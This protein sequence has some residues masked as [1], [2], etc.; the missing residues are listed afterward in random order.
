MQNNQFFST[1]LL[2]CLLWTAKLR[3]LPEISTICCLTFL[4]TCY[5]LL[6]LLA[7]VTIN[8]KNS[9]VIKNR[10]YFPRCYAGLPC[11]HLPLRYFA[12]LQTAAEPCCNLIQESNNSFHVYVTLFPKLHVLQ[13]SKTYPR[14]VLRKLHYFYFSHVKLLH[15]WGK[16][17]YLALPVASRSTYFFR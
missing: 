14:G 3:S 7:T 16:I 9:L 4:I 15:I 10:K 12:I 1:C 13:S 6:L 2:A 5:P 17:Y 8:S 11:C